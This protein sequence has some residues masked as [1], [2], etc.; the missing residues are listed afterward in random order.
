MLLSIGVLVETAVI[1]PFSVCAHAQSCPTLCDPVDYSPPASSVHGVFQV[2][3]LEWVAISYSRGSSQPRHQTRVSCIGRPILY[4][5]ATWED[6]LC[7]TCILIISICVVSTDSRYCC[8]M[9][10]CIAPGFWV[11]LTDLTSLKEE[12]LVSLLLPQRIGLLANLIL[13]LHVW[14][15]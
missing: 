11:L 5:W 13:S 1:N 10:T 6:S 15:L 4:H 3:I 12:I 2:R 7:S 9:W 14:P 8:L